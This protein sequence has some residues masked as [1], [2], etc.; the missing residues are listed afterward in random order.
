MQ[1]YRVLL[2]TENTN[3]K[4]EFFE[5]L[6]L[7][8]CE[9][10]L[11]A[12]E[13]KEIIAK[14]DFSVVALDASSSGDLST[15]LKLL[16][17]KGTEPPVVVII[18]EGAMDVAAQALTSGAFDFLMKPLEASKTVTVI[19]KSAE[20]GELLKQ[21]LILKPQIIG[22]EEKGRTLA[23]LKELA[24]RNTPI[25][26]RGEI[27]TGVE[28][29]AK[30]I[31]FNSPRRDAP[32]ITIDCSS[33]P[34][35]LLESELFGFEKGAVAGGMI[36]KMGQV[37]LAEG[38]T[39]FLNGVQSLDLQTQL[40]LARTIVSGAVTRGDETS[41][42]CDVRFIV[43]T[44]HNLEELIRSRMFREDLFKILS[45]YVIFLP[46]LRER[47]EDIPDLVNY[48][49]E[50]YRRLHRRGPIIF[51]ETILKRLSENP[52]PGNLVEL[53]KAIE[54]YVL[55]GAFPQATSIPSVEEV[56]GI[57]PVRESSRTPPK[58]NPLKEASRAAERE[59]IIE[60]LKECGGNKRMA[61]RTLRISY[62][63][64]FNKLH[65]YNIVTKRDFE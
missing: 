61:A 55:L 24:R 29:V 36:R 49:L 45:K 44:E 4:S 23:L 38:G 47:K 3:L 32:F 9:H 14:E 63:T 37:E 17:I 16:S 43:A 48:Y 5:H 1:K 62:K 54:R 10:V 20:A 51:S 52:W 28:I 56:T 34:P 12:N 42:P 64:L 22:M 31:H 2:I 15:D 27:G 11:T 57:H 25:L 19:L 40:M 53:Q 6:R 41:V 21:T 35:H 50:K 46:P 13:A 8:E 58:P 59:K 7:H 65:Q 33:M 18:E 60:V 30:A 39:L 26:I